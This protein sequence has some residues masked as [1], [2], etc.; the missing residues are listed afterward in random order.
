MGKLYG[1]QGIGRFV[2]GW[3]KGLIT[4]NISKVSLF[5]YTGYLTH[6]STR[7][8]RGQI[9]YA[10]VSYR[11]KLKMFALKGELSIGKKGVG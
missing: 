3:E 5:V 7:C 11:T 10:R 1:V 6:M 8:R 2:S 9:I 4:D